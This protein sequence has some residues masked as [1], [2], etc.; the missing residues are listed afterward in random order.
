MFHVQNGGNKGFPVANQTSL[1][2]GYKQ[3]ETLNPS[4]LDFNVLKLQ[5]DF[6]SIISHDI[7]N[8]TTIINMALNMLKD[9]SKNAETY[10]ASDEKSPDGVVFDAAK[11]SPFKSMEMISKYTFEIDDLIKEMSTSSKLI[12]SFLNIKPDVIKVSSLLLYMSENLSLDGL[13]LMIGDNVYSNKVLGS[14]I[15]VDLTFLHQLISNIVSFIERTYDLE[16]IV[17]IQADVVEKDYCKVLELKVSCQ[18]FSDV[19]LDAKYLSYLLQ[20]GLKR[21]RFP[22][23]IVEKATSFMDA[24]FELDFD[25]PSNPEFRIDLWMS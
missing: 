15:N 10:E 17:A 2:D 14:S 12:K 5:S 24:E 19:K 6:L 20:N 25:D 22:I 16:K 18:F 21:S 4:Y 7:R 1:S 11:S 3:I 8:C 23:F 9:C 13:S